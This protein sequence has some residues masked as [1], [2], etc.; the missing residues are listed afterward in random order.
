MFFN[1]TFSA[2]RFSFAIVLFFLLNTQMAWSQCN[3]ETWEPVGFVSLTPTNTD[4]SV[5]VLS[6]CITSSEKTVMDDALANAVTYKF[7]SSIPTDF[8]TIRNAQGG[9]VLATGYGSVNVVP[10]FHMISMHINTS[11]ACDPNDAVCRTTTV[12]CLN[13]ELEP[14]NCATVISPANNSKVC[15]IQGFTL[16]WNPVEGAEEYDFYFGN[17]PNPPFGTTFGNQVTSTDEFFLTPGVFYWKIV[18]KNAGGSAAGC[19]VWKFT[20]GDTEKP[21]IECPANIVVNNEA[22]KCYRTVDYVSSADDNCAIKFF[23][24][25]IGKSSGSEF[26]VGTTPIKIIAEDESG[27]TT[28]CN[29]SITVNDTQKPSITCPAHILKNTDPNACTASAAYAQPQTND[30]C[31]VESLT[32]TSGFPSNY[33]F[34]VGITVNVFKVSD[35]SG[36]TATCAFNVT[37]KDVQKPTIACPVDILKNNDPGQ[38][39]AM[40]EFQNAQA[41]DNCGIGSVTQTSGLPSGAIFPVGNTVNVWKATDIHANTN[42]CAFKISVQDNEKPLIVCPGD[43]ERNIDP[44]K[45]SAVV[46]YAIAIGHDNC[47]LQEVVRTEGLPSGSAFPV[48]VTNVVYR[49]TDIHANTATC[50]FSVKVIDNENPSFVC[51]VNLTK[52]NDFGKCGRHMENIGSPNQIKDNC[53]IQSVTN[54]SPVDFPVGETYV[55]WKVLDIH[56]NSATCVQKVTIIDHEWPVVICPQNMNLTTTEGECEAIGVGFSATATDNCPGVVLQYDIEPKSNFPLGYTNI[57]AIAT[58][59]VGHQV[60]C[61]FQ[62]IVDARK[63]ICNG[64]DDDC[65]GYTDEVQDWAQILKTSALNGKQGDEYGHSVAIRGDWAIVGMNEKNQANMNMGSA[66]LLRRS[67]N[68]PSDWYEV[69]KLQA[70]GILL[71]DAFGVSVAISEG[72]AVVG[73]PNANGKGAAFIFR[74]SP[75]DENEWVF[76]KTITAVDGAQGDAFGQ[77]LALH[78]ETL[79]VGAPS[80]NEVAENAG[81]VYIFGKNTGGNENWGQ[82][83]KQTAANG[84]ANDQLGTSVAIDGQNAIAGATG[85]DQ[86]GTNVGAAYIFNQNTGGA[87]N[88]GQA[89]KLTANSGASGDNFGTSVGISGAYA[90]IGASMD[91]DKGQNAGTAFIFQ[92]TANGWQQSSKLVDYN[93][94]EGDEYGHSVSIAGDYA[95]VGAR[96]NDRKATKAGAAFVYHREDGGWV[97]FGILTDG[98]GKSDD[99]FGSA[100]A[101]YGTTIFVGAPMDDENGNNNRGSASIFEGLCSPSDEREIAQDLT[102]FENEGLSNFKMKAYPVPFAEV[103]NIALE[104]PKTQLLSIRVFN[105]LGQQVAILHNGPAEGHVE[106]KW[107]AMAAPAGVYSIRIESEGKLE[108]KQVTRVEE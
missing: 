34:P 23:Y 44:G 90:I 94:N 26:P 20:V 96:K 8:I 47:G 61:Q 82:I 73:A 1:A 79:L 100:V 81:A 59:H 62:I 43:M 89:A 97:Q 30:N 5:Q 2:I 66:Y 3:N 103:L 17:A 98:S 6:D 51:P 57:E 42:T 53:G 38:C 48:G 7:S 63:E 11:N 55:T 93:G 107:N 67:A 31:G 75:D 13:C 28:V 58:D 10:I 49:A 54:D 101:I 76:A 87:D 69:E 37:V 40:V 72:L 25:D 70:P 74:Q 12:Q 15:P 56:D 71:G 104:V 106:F 50:G 36:N 86:K 108:T 9:A 99:Q 4:G 91:D 24:L 19:P 85:D 18:P 84:S 80:D 60:K 105:V 35:G 68:E 92:K 45:C 52:P 77:S 16:N 32:Q 27:N 83:K 41:F 102:T 29:F 22:N 95:V 88:W 78:A 33:D 14:P 64:L 39:S 46:N 21:T 65:D